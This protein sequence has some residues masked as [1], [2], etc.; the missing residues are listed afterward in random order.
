MVIPALQIVIELRVSRLPSV[1]VVNHPAEDDVL[2]RGGPV[3]ED[4][5]VASLPNLPQN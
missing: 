5:S 3:I 2:W 1:K 4:E